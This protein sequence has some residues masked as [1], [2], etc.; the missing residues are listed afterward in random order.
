MVPD[1]PDVLRSAAQSSDA[2]N[3]ITL[4]TSTADQGFIFCMRRAGVNL[5]PITHFTT[6]VDSEGLLDRAVTSQRPRRSLL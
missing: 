3:V 6:D 1:I 5:Y 4:D 2:Y